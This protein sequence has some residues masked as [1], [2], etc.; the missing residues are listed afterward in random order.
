MLLKKK[1]TLN[2]LFVLN[3]LNV[4]HRYILSARELQKLKIG[5]KYLVFSQSSNKHPDC[6]CTNTMTFFS[7]LN[8][9][10]WLPCVFDTGGGVDF[11]FEYPC[12]NSNKFAMMKLT[13]KK[14]WQKSRITVLFYEGAQDEPLLP[15]YK[16]S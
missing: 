12:K 9:M 6:K 7:S 1:I 5:W 13:D 8:T 4:A 10:Y 11:G 16:Q 3:S 2:V 14:S 15:K